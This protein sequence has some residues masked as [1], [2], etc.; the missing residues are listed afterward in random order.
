MRFSDTQYLCE[1]VILASV[2]KK[3]KKKK[4]EE[5]SLSSNLY[6]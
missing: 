6:T 3:K 5:E 1:L 4:E 2:P